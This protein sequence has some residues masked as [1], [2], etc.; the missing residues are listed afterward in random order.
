MVSP[1]CTTRPTEEAPKTF[2][3]ACPARVSF[4]ERIRE[5]TG[6]N[7]ELVKSGYEAFNEA[8]MAGVL[9]LVAEHAEW[10]LTP[11]CMYGGTH[12][13]HAGIVEGIFDPIA[14]DWSEWFPRPREFLEIG[15]TIVVLGDYHAVVR[16]SGTRI[17][18]P[19]VHVWR[20]KHGQVVRLDQ[21]TDTHIIRSA[22]TP[23]SRS[24]EPPAR[25]R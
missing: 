4:G 5:S 12:R 16:S 21:V 25:W 19:F 14:G 15:D 23:P 11:G 8:D 24:N 13:G 20:L 10:R 22:L 9:A 1:T 18:A 17:V 2:I 6:T 7:T 3:P